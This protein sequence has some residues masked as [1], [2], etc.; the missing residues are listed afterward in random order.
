[1]ILVIFSRII[2]TGEIYAIFS[3]ITKLFGARGA[4]GFFVSQ[5]TARYQ[6]IAQ[7]TNKNA[8]KRLTNNTSERFILC[9]PLFTPLRVG[10]LFLAL[11]L[12]FFRAALAQ[13]VL[14]FC[15]LIIAHFVELLPLFRR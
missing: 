10:F 12:V 8:R 3:K 2:P 14:Y 13:A 6:N 11:L 4:C 9:I 1:M 5:K 15:S 7:D